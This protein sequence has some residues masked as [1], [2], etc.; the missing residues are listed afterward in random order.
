MAWKKQKRTFPIVD[1]Y[2]WEGLRQYIV[3]FSFLIQFYSI[4]FARLIYNYSILFTIAVFCRIQNDMY[5]LIGTHDS[6]IQL[7]QWVNTH[8][9]CRGQSFFHLARWVKLTLI[10]AFLSQFVPYWVVLNISSEYFS[11]VFRVFLRD[12]LDSL[13]LTSQINFN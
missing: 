6:L 8:N 4:T 10:A 9:K 11:L 1:R 7:S 12:L 5:H 2:S 3:P 13:P